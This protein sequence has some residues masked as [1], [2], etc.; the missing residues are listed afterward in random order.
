MLVATI[1]LS[2][3][4]V[5]DSGLK[6]ASKNLTS[7]AIEAL[8]SNDYL[9]SATQTI[10]YKNSTG[11]TLESICMH[12]YPRAFREDATI[13]PYTNLNEASCFPNG[14]NYGDI[15]ISR[16]N[17]DGQSANFEFV[18]E[19][20]DILRI[21]LLDKLKA[22]DILK[23]EI[24][25]DLTI[26]NCTHRFGYY[27]STIN[28]GNWYPVVCAYKNG[29]WETSPYYSTGDPFVSE[30]ANYEVTISYPQE[31]LC[32]ATGNET[33]TTQNKAQSSK[34]DTQLT[35][36]GNTQTQTSKGDTQLTQTGCTQ[37]TKSDMQLT[38]TGNTQ[39]SKSTFLA[40]AVRDFA[41]VLIKNSQSKTTKTQDTSVTYV[42]YEGDADIE[43]NS[44]LAALATQY[45]CKAFGKYPYENLVVI[46]SAFVQG[47]M[48]YPNIVLVSDNITEAKEFQKVIVHE[49]AHQWWY[50]L[51]GNDQINQAWLDESLAEYSTCLFYEDNPE[52]QIS[53][54]DQIK[55]ATAS[56][57]IYV[58]VIS[59]LNGKVNTSMNLP[60]NKYA[61]EYE[62]TYMIYV[63]GVIMFDSLREVVGKEKFLAALKKY[64]KQNCY[65]IANEEDLIDAFENTCH[66]DLQSFFSGWLGGTNII[67]YVD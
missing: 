48:E 52:F 13:L 4:G 33:Q 34:S 14:K 11:A 40:A 16:V 44:Q 47:G 28:L 50:G 18:G 32:Y 1:T 17:V 2:C 59:S 55:D 31:Y 65:K 46:K 27:G 62:Y 19:D 60:V 58:D 57:L 67:G 25:F 26:P 7:Y 12:L 15:T 9:V 43:Q 20:K 54:S 8:L 35:Q 45:F 5:F 51:V 21:N 22:K 6:K 10:N 37:T 56:Y 53:Y 3:F 36:T 42:G 64:F 39:T 66:M 38:Q 23:I 61:S 29:E 41:L 49:I 24:D 63:K 30:C